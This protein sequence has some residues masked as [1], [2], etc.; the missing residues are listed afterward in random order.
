MD[1]KTLRKLSSIEQ[2]RL[3]FEDTPTLSAVD[4]VLQLKS[5]SVADTELFKI[6]SG[7]PGN[8]LDNYA[9][10]GGSFHTLGIKLAAA[11]SGISSSVSLFGHQKEAVDKVVARDGNLLLSHPVGSGKTLTSIAAFEALRDAGKA[12]RA[13][14][15]V[16]ASLRENYLMNGI[17][18]FTNSKGAIFGTSQE[19]KNGTHASLEKP[20]KDARYHIISYEMYRKDPKAYIEAAGADTVI[21]DE[22]HKAKNEGVKTTEAIKAAR[23]FHRNFIGMTGSII[24]NTPADIVPLIDAMT[25]G[26][27]ALGNKTTF[28]SRFVRKDDKGEKKL[29]NPQVLK[30]LLV[31]YVHHVDADSLNTGAPTKHVEEVRV[32][33]SD[34]QAQLYK[35]VT[36]KLDPLTRLALKAGVSKLNGAELNNV[37]TKLIRLRQLSNSVHTMDQSMSVA[38]SAHQTPKI[39]KIL[40]DVVEHIKETPDA[41]VVLH[42]N[43]IVGGVDVLTA[44]L[45]QRGIDHALFI[46]KGQP[47]VTEASRQHGVAEYQAG[48][49][50][51]IVLS[52]AG[53]EGLDLPNTTF[54]GMTDGHFNPEKINQA[55]ARGIRAGG[56]S[57]RDKKDRNV[58]VRRYVSVLPSGAAHLSDVGMGIWDN[59][60]PAAITARVVSGG[61]AFYNP[62]KKPKSTDEWIYG[63]AKSK[64]GLN[65]AT[66][67]IM[68]TAGLEDKLY[69]A[70]RVMTNPLAGAV[71]GAAAGALLGGTEP[72]TKR[73]IQQDPGAARRNRISSMI[74][75]AVG[76]AGGSLLI[77]QGIIMPALYGTLGMAEAGK[78]IGSL[79]APVSKVPQDVLDVLGKGHTEYSDVKVFEKYW[80][81]FGKELEHKGINTEVDKEKEQKFINALRSIYTEVAAT[82]APGAGSFMDGR[83]LGAN[84]QSTGA[85]TRKKFLLQATAGALIPATLLGTLAAVQDHQMTQLGMQE[86][87][88]GGPKRAAIAALATALP[89]VIEGA[90]VG[91]KRYRDIFVD[92]GV[93]AKSKPDARFRRTFVDDQF[94]Q[95]LRGQTVDQIKV[96]KHAIS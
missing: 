86:G 91:L 59:I 75:G 45:K 61:D 37:F 60:N 74:G 26:S 19:V 89:S 41:Q 51:V 3:Y 13:L 7:L 30:S 79:R 78:A 90:A 9:A 10:L 77:R 66:H 15:V 17:K 1:T 32:E 39:K 29:N 33:M 73:E 25:G 34:R 81:T 42:T 49:K 69:L 11:P 52:A 68:K 93:T 40:D 38:D 55:E 56:L 50:R 4:E 84:G 62:F 80:D 31:P 24:S 64:G 83:A 47:G 43:L 76:G 18:K 88:V 44:G 23:P 72:R 21:Y 71:L 8:S 20:Q 14:V 95:L 53:G 70:H 28:E 67:N 85:P 82:K 16:P 27:H 92:P 58:I 5:A 48:R 87:Q 12:K 2:G 57:H 54:M 22:L 63:V 35:F 96:K 65:A 6:A 94:R 36:D 46:G